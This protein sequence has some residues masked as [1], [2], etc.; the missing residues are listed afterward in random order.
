MKTKGPI[1]RTA[2]ATSMARMNAMGTV[3]KR[4]AP[5]GGARMLTKPWR[6]M[7]NP[8]TLDSYSFSTIIDVEA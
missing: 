7:L 4:R 6:L 2:V 5:K 3:S 8:D 1:A